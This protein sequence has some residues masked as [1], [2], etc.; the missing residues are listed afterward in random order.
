VPGSTTKARIRRMPP[1]ISTGLWPG[2]S[3]AYGASKPRSRTQS[4]SVD[5]D[6][7]RSG[8]TFTAATSF[9]GWFRMP[10]HPCAF[11]WTA[12]TWAPN[13][14]GVSG[15][16]RRP[17]T[18]HVHRA[19]QCATSE[20]EQAGPRGASHHHHNPTLFSMLKGEPDIDPVLEEGSMFQSGG[21]AAPPVEL[22][23]PVLSHRDVRLHR[24]RRVSP[25]DLQSLAAGAEYFDASLIGLTATAFQA[26]SRLLNQTW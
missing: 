20:I 12:T 22:D 2:Q 24:H 1:L 25:V 10:M 18:A 8:K 5:P 16:F 14:E 21:L 9:T 4:P 11:S 26:D 3:K 15:L 19:V 6:G 7:H 23:T 13:A 17:T